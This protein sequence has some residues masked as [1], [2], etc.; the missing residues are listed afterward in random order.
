[1]RALLVAVLLLWA[2][3]AAAEGAPRYVMNSGAPV[4]LLDTVTGASWVL[5]CPA[6]TACAHQWSLIPGGPATI[7]H[8]DAQGNPVP[9]VNPPA[10]GRREAPPPPPGFRPFTPGRG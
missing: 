10:E 3:E 9:G 4:V 1:M 8:F 5:R 7:L 6:L 2:G